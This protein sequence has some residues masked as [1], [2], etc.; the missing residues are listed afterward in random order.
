[1]THVKSVKTASGLHPALKWV[2]ASA[3][4]I[5]YWQNA[6]NARDWLPIS[7]VRIS[8]VCFGYCY[9]SGL[10]PGPT[11]E[12]RKGDSLRILDCRHDLQ[13]GRGSLRSCGPSESVENLGSDAVV[14]VARKKTRG[15]EPPGPCQWRDLMQERSRP[16]GTLCTADQ[17]A[18]S[19]FAL[20]H[21]LPD[22]GEE[23]SESAVP[24]ATCIWDGGF[25]HFRRSGVIRT[26][27]ACQCS[28]SLLPTS[29]DPQPSLNIDQQFAKELLFVWQS[30][31]YNRMLRPA[32]QSREIRN[33][34]LPGRLCLPKV[35]TVC[36]VR[37]R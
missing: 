3:R 36:R 37:L 9:V 34:V 12:P 2:R 13:I 28:G 1:M 7:D 33:L 24:L 23:A 25:P 20:E 26:D 18:G 10:K 29:F 16:A 32:R 5:G 31:R 6:D 27:F 4:N 11:C 22:R 17:N 8:A 21:V 30:H 15:P 35:F 19:R 14:D